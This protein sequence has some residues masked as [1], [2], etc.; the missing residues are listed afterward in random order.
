MII[1]NPNISAIQVTL[2]NQKHNSRTVLITFL[3][4]VHLALK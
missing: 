1:D 3:D 2:N 4:Y